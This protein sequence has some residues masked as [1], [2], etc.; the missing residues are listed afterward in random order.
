[1]T[2]HK[3]TV[4]LIA[5]LITMSLAGCSFS[6]G[7]PWGELDGRAGALSLETSKVSTE[8]VTLER[9]TLNANIFLETVTTS[10]GGGGGAFDPS[11]PPP[12][13]T[14]CHNGHCHSEDG[15]LVSYEDVK[16]NLNASGGTSTSTVGQW[17]TT[18]DLQSGQMVRLPAIDISQRTTID[19]IKVEATNLVLE[20]DIESGD[21]SVPLEAELGQF[22]LGST[23]GVSLQVGPDQ[24]YRQTVELCT[25]WS[26]NW[27]DNIDISQLN[28]QEGTVRLTRILNADA[29]NQLVDAARQATIEL[30][31]CQP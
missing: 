13:Y 21:A 27:F 9:A 10:S 3:T 20:G 11:N 29:T 17:T 2:M 28:R 22:E 14:L 4:E 18:I 31:N 16:A 15:E 19:R 5:L 23:D 30:S 12:G 25:N 7:Q 24:P 8:E 1:M 26:T 6:D